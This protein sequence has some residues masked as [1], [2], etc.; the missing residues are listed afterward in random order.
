MELPT[1]P[2]FLD[3]TLFGILFYALHKCVFRS[4]ILFGIVSL[5]LLAKVGH[6]QSI[7]ADAFWL[8]FNLLLSASLLLGLFLA[9]RSANF[10]WLFSG[11]LLVEIFDLSLTP[12][13][14]SQGSLFYIWTILF[15]GVILF[16]LDRRTQIVRW[17]ASVCRGEL[18]RWAQV[19]APHQ[20]ESYHEVFLML[21]YWIYII[22]SV[23][24]LIEYVVYHHYGWPPGFFY[25]TYS[26]VKT[27]LNVVELGLL[28]Y[29]TTGRAFTL[30]GRQPMH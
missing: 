12:L 27:P 22:Y 15:D 8:V 11:L 4:P 30:F 3:L 6:T 28:F 2:P 5:L 18:Q 17:M 13:L 29:L 21:I 23:L 10:F 9:Q 16:L 25:K 14:T 24:T 7:Q 1:L 19:A 20:R 26:L